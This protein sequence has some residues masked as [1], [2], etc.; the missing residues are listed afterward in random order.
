MKEYTELK[1]KTVPPPELTSTERL[2]EEY[3]HIGTQKFIQLLSEL[4]KS[5]LVAYVKALSTDFRDNKLKRMRKDGLVDLVLSRV[6][7][8][9]KSK[10]KPT[11]QD[12]IGPLIKPS[13]KSGG[14][15][16][17]EASVDKDI[18]LGK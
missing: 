7:K 11:E 14:E 16:D 18:R 6:K 1:E 10:E 12:N 3:Q 9:S 15:H 2:V 17:R 4:K 8:L 5:E 13:T